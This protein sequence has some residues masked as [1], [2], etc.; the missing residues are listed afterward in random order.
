MFERLRADLAHHYLLDAGQRNPPLLQRIRA[1][2]EAPALQ[3]TVVFRFGSFIHGSR[4]P[5]FVRKPLGL[6]YFVLDKITIVMWGV[7]I[8]PGAQIAGGLYVGHTG[9]ILIGPVTMGPDCC[10]AHNVTIGLRADRRSRNVPVIGARVWVGSGAIV[11]GGITIGDGVSIGPLSVVG[12]N[13]A[14]GTLVGGNPMQ[15]LSR[16]YENTALV[17]GGRAKGPESH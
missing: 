13:V 8:D 12:R 6:L 17:Y 11:F 14:P 5:W 15:V 10:V 4:L 2:A 16:G 7:H 3:G 1:I 9:G